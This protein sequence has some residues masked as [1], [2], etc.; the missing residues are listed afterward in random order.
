MT[1]A[2]SS[3]SSNYSSRASSVKEQPHR[4]PHVEWDQPSV[5]PTG[6]TVCAVE[7]D[8]QNKVASIRSVHGKR[9]TTSVPL[10]ELFSTP[11]TNVRHSTVENVQRPTNDQKPISTMYNTA[12]RSSDGC[13]TRITNR[14]SSQSSNGDSGSGLTH[15]SDRDSV[16][17]C[18]GVSD[19][20][21]AASGN[22][23]QTCPAVMRQLE[24]V[25]TR[26]CTGSAAS[27]CV[28]AV[29]PSPRSEF[30]RR[31]RPVSVTESTS[32]MLPTPPPPPPPARKPPLPDHLRS[33]MDSSRTSETSVDISPRNIC[34]HQQIHQP[35]LAQRD[36]DVPLCDLHQQNVATHF[37]S[38]FT[39]DYK[40]VT[41][42]SSKSSFP[43]THSTDVMNTNC[44]RNSPLKTCDE[45]RPHSQ[46]EIS[47]TAPYTDIAEQ[48]EVCT[49]VGSFAQRL[50][51]L[52]TFYE[53]SGHDVPSNST[54]SATAETDI[55]RRDI[56]DGIAPSTEPFLCQQ[57]AVFTHVRPS[58]TAPIS[59]SV[60][61]AGLSES[62]TAGND[63]E[64]AVSDD[65]CLLLPPPPEFD[66]S[67]ILPAP[68]C[69]TGS[70]Y[71][72]DSARNAGV[73]DWSVD[74]VCNW[75]D[76]VGLCD[77]CASFRMGNVSGSRLKTLGRSEL[78]ALGLADV[79]DR[80][81][82]ER[83]LRKALNS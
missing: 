10:R 25:Q 12:R 63:N 58:A 32:R 29:R 53:R 60:L 59:E 26:Q 15:L 35:T 3:L 77:H 27:Q 11:T 46:H 78:I 57:D 44:T 62:L 36:G 6:N 21:P 61:S 38:E 9:L 80:M 69:F 65:I 37:D 71:H 48:S 34:S 81:K 82:F 40:S 83:A 39:V 16:S 74:E 64:A 22:G 45:D 56:A 75:L 2:I 19:V 73:D 67:F 1:N 55:Y 51:H 23:V 18:N 70:T 8:A 68:S 79:Y 14:R 47:T 33:Q 50:N 72:S 43:V 7:N 41:T 5:F 49:D 24:D 30:G 76:T 31:R 20:W 66:D 13:H 17:N 54:P 52:K 42:R 4:L 28:A